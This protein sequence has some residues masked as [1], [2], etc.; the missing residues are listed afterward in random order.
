MAD[1]KCCDRCGRY[2]KNN[3]LRMNGT[4]ASVGSVGVFRRDNPLACSASYEL[5]ESCANAFLDF[6]N[7]VPTTTGK[8]NPDGN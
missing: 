3:I 7:M 4:I 1:A 2:Y 5:C 6:I 8:E